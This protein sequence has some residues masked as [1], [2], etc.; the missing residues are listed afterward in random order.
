MFL[1]KHKTPDMFSDFM[2]TFFANAMPYIGL[3]WAISFAAFI[4]LIQTR[5]L[6]QKTSILNPLADVQDIGKQYVGKDAQ[7]FP[8]VSLLLAVVCILCPFRLIIQKYCIM[9]WDIE[10]ANK[11]YSNLV[12]SFPT[13]YDKE[14]PLT[15]KKGDERWLNI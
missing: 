4:E 12:T 11:R 8:V 2:A 7:M 13:D 6:K 15:K 5:N 3:L 1:R 10:E 9:D 14:N